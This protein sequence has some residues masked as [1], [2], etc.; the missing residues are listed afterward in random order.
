MKQRVSAFTTGISL[1]AMAIIGGYALGFA[2][3]SFYPLSEVAGYSEKMK[4]AIVLYK[5]MLNC[6]AIVLLLDLIVSYTIFS[7]FKE[8]DNKTAFICA[9]LRVVYTVIFGLSTLYLV[10][11]LSYDHLTNSQ[12]ES[13]FELFFRVWNLGLTL[14]GVHVFLVGLL[15][16][17]QGSIPSYLWYTTLFAGIC[18]TALYLL[19]LAPYSQP[20]ATI[21][22]P[23]LV[24][25]MAVGELGLAI[26]LLV[27]S[28]KKNNS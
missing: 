26:W 14:F 11:N 2:L 6:I 16:K 20:L 15:M 9:I 18:Y 17:A 25:P 3:P 4:D 23:V 7:F 10:K 1:V 22:E 8:V 12:L 13:N 27:K 24:L 28:G 5:N 19:K 21:L